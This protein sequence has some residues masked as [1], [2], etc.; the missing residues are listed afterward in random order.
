[1]EQSLE[2]RIVAIFVT[3]FASLLGVALPLYYVQKIG[4]ESMMNHVGFSLLRSFSAGIMIGVSLIHLLADASSELPELYP[5]YPALPFTLATFG[6]IFVLTLE[7]M[8]LTFLKPSHGS[9][10]HQV[11]YYADD[12]HH[13]QHSHA[14]GNDC[15]GK[16]CKDIEAV[17]QDVL[18]TSAAVKFNHLEPKS[19]GP[20]CQHQHSHASLNV[21]ADSR[22][23]VLLIKA[24]VM[25]VAIAIHSIIIG[26]S[27]GLMGEDEISSIQALTIAMAFHQLFEGVSLGVA[28]APIT[29]KLGTMKII[30]FSVVFGTM[31]SIGII[32]GILVSDNLDEHTHQMATGCL[33]AIAA[34]SLIYI[35]LVEMLAEEFSNELLVSK[36]SQKFAMIGSFSFGVSF[37]AILAVWA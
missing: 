5:D 12:G 11:S 21:L 26:L 15:D 37:M 31:L 28:I 13:H 22:S 14:H 33:N 18:V 17:G 7:N 9:S 6:V 30:I 24:Y 23:F 2:L 34:G 25:E 29:A 36:H 10:E 27:L 35:S 4:A 32:I 3:L 19:Q 20:K 8:A 1:M 16:L